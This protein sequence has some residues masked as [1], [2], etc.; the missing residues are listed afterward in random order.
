MTNG[1]RL[2]DQRSLTAQLRDLVLLANKNGLYDAADW[3]ET[4]LRQSQYQP[5]PSEATSQGVKTTLEALF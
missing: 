2:N 4:H 5:T 3:V 1:I